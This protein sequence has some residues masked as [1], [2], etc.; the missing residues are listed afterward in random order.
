MTSPREWEEKTFSNLR[1]ADDCRGMA[2]Y[3]QGESA[4]AHNKTRN[5]NLTKYHALDKSLQ[6]KLSTTT[7]LQQL[8]E[9]RLLAVSSQ[10]HKMRHSAETLRAAEKSLLAP[11]EL[12]RWRKAQ[13]A[14]RPGREKILDEV[15]RA[16]EY[17]QSVLRDAYDRFKKQQG[18]TRW[19]IEQLQANGVAL[20]ADLT[21]KVESLKTDGK[22]KHLQHVP[23]SNQSASPPGGCSESG[24]STARLV[25]DYWTQRNQEREE[26][27]VAATKERLKHAKQTEQDAMNLDAESVDL[28]KH[29]N[30]A[31]DTAKHQT[32]KALDDQISKT[33]NL[34]DQIRK[35]IAQTEESIRNTEK[36]MSLTNKERHGHRTPLSIAGKKEYWRSGRPIRE[37]IQDPVTTNLECHL[38]SLEKNQCFLGRRQVVEATRRGELRK[39]KQFLLAD[40]RDKTAFLEIDLDCRASNT[41][42]DMD[43]KQNVLC[44]SHRRS[45]AR[46]H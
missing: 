26:H 43:P 24:A 29:L 34:R 45:A 27:R 15:E 23:W 12:C 11:T 6:V 32:E 35:A 3:D 20:Q 4:H 7:E 17:E 22:C 36:T 41:V 21:L 18:K 5:E 31:R 25:P 30:A 38:R 33:K 46:C 42:N 8:L 37:N 40:L 9:R 10:I 44:F 19:I 14:Q 39:A 13:R 1:H 28:I 16:L 2:T